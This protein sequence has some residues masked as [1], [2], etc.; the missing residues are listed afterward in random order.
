MDHTQTPPL[1]ER[2]QLLRPTKA[3]V[4]ILLVVI[5][6]TFSIFGTISSFRLVWD[7][8]TVLAVG[9]AI[10]G[11]LQNDAQPSLFPSSSVSHP[12]S[13][14]LNAKECGW[15]DGDPVPI[16]PFGILVFPRKRE[17][18]KSFRQPRRRLLSVSGGKLLGG[19]SK[20]RG[21]NIITKPRMNPIDRRG[22]SERVD[23]YEYP[24]NEP[25]HFSLENGFR[26]YLNTTDS[27][28]GA[29][30]TSNRK[31]VEVP[32]GCLR[33]QHDRR[34][35]ILFTPG[36]CHF[37]NYWHFV[38]ECVHAVAHVMYTN[39][40]TDSDDVHL[41]M[42]LASGAGQLR[43]SGSFVTDWAGQYV[44]PCPRG[45]GAT[46][47]NCSLDTNPEDKV[48][49]WNI[50]YTPSKLRRKAIGLD[51]MELMMYPPK[52]LPQHRETRLH[53][54]NSKTKTSDPPGLDILG[55]VLLSG[56]GRLTEP[57]LTHNDR[58]EAFSYAR[59]RIMAAL[60]LSHDDHAESLSKSGGKE[61]LYISRG[62][63]AQR[64]ISNEAD[65]ITGLRGIM[66]RAEFN[67]KIVNAEK[68]SAEE[69]VSVWSSVDLA[70]VE[71]GAGNANVLFLRPRTAVVYISNDG[72]Y[73][74]YQWILPQT[75]HYKVF[76]I[77]ALPD[78]TNSAATCRIRV[79]RVLS[80][81]TNATRYL[82]GDQ[83][84]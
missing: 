77:N 81:V 43:R 11:Q 38:T 72:A 52:S 55:D 69:Q 31:S 33:K 48:Q 82:R 5:I 30:N 22:K 8:V 12:V 78:C 68:L 35:V 64:K 2:R 17:E 3:F 63:A 1:T 47:W 50:M 65:L 13:T 60:G 83:I 57:G 19:G 20:D 26:R 75:G 84:V 36:N 16:K 74:T 53:L 71:R 9:K 40:I 6:S 54:Y 45:I 27:R 58:P 59:R 76:P 67:F 34:R 61:A 51:I 23:R 4:F 62:N 42:D 15:V 73:D 14:A 41:I 24:D 21:I 46:P 18:S 39:N 49:W 80:A 66:A 37:G 44:N 32:N 10:K 28:Y 70:I 25:I 7:S 29:Y 56:T 79:P